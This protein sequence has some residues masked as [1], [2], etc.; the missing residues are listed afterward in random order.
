MVEVERREC[1]ESNARQ[2]YATHAFFRYFGKLP[3]TVTRRIL[4]E[5]RPYLA[6]GPGVDLACGS[7]TTLVEAALLG[8]PVEGLDI[9]PP[10]VLTSRVKTD[11][12]ERGAFE[13]EWQTREV[14][15]AQA[16]YRRSPDPEIRT[17]RDHIL[18]LEPG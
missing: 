15:F 17:P 12:P 8:L 6:N 1:L 2:Q 10:S 4:R 11:P 13:R 16:S 9:N 18:F 5:S 14:R 7:G 3:P